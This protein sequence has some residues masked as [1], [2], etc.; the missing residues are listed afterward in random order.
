MNSTLPNA[1]ST[2]PIPWLADSTA[3]V[4]VRAA[5]DRGCGACA[6]RTIVDAFAEDSI[7]VEK[8][9]S[10]TCASVLWNCPSTMSWEADQ[11]DSHGLRPSV[12]RSTCDVV[13]RSCSGDGEI[14]PPGSGRD[15]S[16]PT[17]LLFINELTISS[18]A[19]PAIGFAGYG[20]RTVGNGDC[21]LSSCHESHDP[22]Q[23]TRPTLKWQQRSRTARVISPGAA[24]GR[25]RII[26]SRRPMIL[27]SRN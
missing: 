3:R 27:I 20:G 5:P 17:S 21:C 8:R 18:T 22:E 12:C 23:V 24:V 26:S 9:R 6:I 25:Q 19:C 16:K 7:S 10:I 13:R 11:R 1:V 4:A 2:V 15:R 14:N